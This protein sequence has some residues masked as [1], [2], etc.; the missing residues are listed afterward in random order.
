[1]RESLWAETH[2]T[3]SS[4]GNGDAPTKAAAAAAGEEWQEACHV[5]LAL[6]RLRALLMKPPAAQ[7]GAV[8]IP[9]ALLPPCG[10]GDEGGGS[11][12]AGMYRCVYA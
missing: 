8:P 5:G 10:A 6:D 3:P 7:P 11:V 2:H 1:M 9:L 4:L 12:V